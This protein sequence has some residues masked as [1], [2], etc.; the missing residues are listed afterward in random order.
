[1]TVRQ[2][3]EVETHR[4]FLVWSESTSLQENFIVGQICKGKLLALEEKRKKFGARGAIIMHEL[5]RRQ[6]YE[7]VAFDLAGQLSHISYF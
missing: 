7:P 5:L 3:R 4:L 1:M 6:D 2:V